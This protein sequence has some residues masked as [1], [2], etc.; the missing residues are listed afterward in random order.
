MKRKNI[1]IIIYITAFVLFLFPVSV[2]ASQPTAAAY[3]HEEPEPPSFEESYIN[4][5]NMEEL[6]YGINE[7]VDILLQAAED[8]EEDETA[9]SL[10]EL[11]AEQNELLVNIERLTMINA[12]LLA[13]IIGGIIGLGFLQLWRPTND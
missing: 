13:I 9:E 2:F 10:E 11:I 12:M 1:F 7:L 6:I 8:D 4:I 5:E 3:D